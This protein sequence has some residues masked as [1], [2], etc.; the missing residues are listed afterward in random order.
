MENKLRHLEMIQNIIGRM[1]NNS[2]LLKGWTVTL[3][4]GI[5][6]ISSKEADKIYFLIAYIPVFVFWGLDSYYLLQERL[7]RSLYDTIR[8]MDEKD[9]DFSLKATSKDF[10]SDKNCYCNC[11]FSKT[12]LWFYLPLALTILLVVGLI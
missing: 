8:D 1:A 4:A 2:F 12:E 9:I 10:L 6:A 3:V 7:Y 11:V 5:F